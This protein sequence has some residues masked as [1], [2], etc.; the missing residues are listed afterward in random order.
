MHDPDV[1]SEQL[2]DH[3]EAIGHIDVVLHHEHTCPAGENG[4]GR[5]S[6]L[7]PGGRQSPYLR[8]LRGVGE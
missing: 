2:E 7:V 8:T 6:W 5:R 4:V 1:V 3:A